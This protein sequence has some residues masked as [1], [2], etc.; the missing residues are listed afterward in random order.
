MQKYD[1]SRIKVFGFA[2]HEIEK[3]AL[4]RGH[5][6]F[7]AVNTL[8]N[9]FSFDKDRG[10]SCTWPAAVFQKVSYLLKP[11]DSPLKKQRREMNEALP[12]RGKELREFNYC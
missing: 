7:E 9:P 1:L 6:P 5:R 8:F 2:S 10:L 12:S 4:F 11:P 3:R